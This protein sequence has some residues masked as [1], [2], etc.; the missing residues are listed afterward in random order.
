MK[1]KDI[2]LFA[3]LIV[4]NTVNA[5]D[6][7]YLNGTNR[8]DFQLKRTVNTYW[9]NCNQSYSPASTTIR[10][11]ASIGRFL[12][13]SDGSGYIIPISGYRGE[14]KVYSPSCG[15]LERKV[16]FMTKPTV[17]TPPPTP[18]P[19]PGVFSYSWKGAI[20]NTSSNDFGPRKVKS[21]RS[22]T[23]ISELNG[24]LYLTTGFS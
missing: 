20:G 4:F 21:L 16:V 18:T 24:Y 12:L 3:L 8:V 17:V 10:S 1:L 15:L 13:K 23:S 11:L 7:V 9:V 5:Q 22:A 6:T 14:W 2:L 19:T